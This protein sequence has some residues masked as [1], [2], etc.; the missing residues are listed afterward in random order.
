[1]NI[2]IAGKNDIASHALAYLVN[3]LKLPVSS[4]KAI[5]SRGDPGKH[6]WQ[7]SLKFTANSLGVEIVPLE[8]SFEDENALFMSLEFDRIIK[9]AKFKTDRL[10]NI[11]FS[12]LPSYRGIGTSVFPILN[13][14]NNTAVT[15]HVVDDGIDTGAIIS[16]RIFRIDEGWT[17]RDLYAAFMR[18]AL[19]LFKDCISDLITGRPRATPQGVMGAT[20]FGP[21]DIN[22][23]DTEINF[24]YCAAQVDRRI[25]AFSFWEFQLP[26]HNGRKILGV[27]ILPIRS[28]GKAG[29]ET[30]MGPYHSII[31]TLDYNIE[32][33]YSPY[34]DLWRWA[35]S[36]RMDNFDLSVVPD[37][38]RQTKE[39]WSAA[40]FASY[41]A[42]DWQLKKL[43]EAGADVN[44]CNSR[45]TSLLMYC[46]SG[47]I[48]RG[49]TQVLEYL[50]SLHPDIWHEDINGK[51]VMQYA[52]EYGREDLAD[53]IIRSVNV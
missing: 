34:D 20:Y 9:T 45:G 29:E 21:S 11:H 40:I 13:G 18:N 30:I 36:E 23:A 15:L 48:Q 22:Y 50:L 46:L 4:L 5:P 26:T 52:R 47:A 33:F 44:Q 43:I 12:K 19:E 25:R 3:D 2:Y 39:G 28:W 6:T 10:Y 38:D 7:H 32:I 16:Q 41:Y 8:S 14:E 37:L 17:S 35:K 49:T 51:N 31:T 1:M 24:R 27:K 42:R 53:V